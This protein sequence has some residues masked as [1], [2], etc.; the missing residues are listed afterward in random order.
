MQWRGDPGVEALLPATPG[1]E[2]GHQQ[3]E[4]STVTDGGAGAT[5]SV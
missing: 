5:A 4:T 1:A 2:P 3:P